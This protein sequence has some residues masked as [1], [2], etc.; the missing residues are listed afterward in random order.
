MRPVQDT[1]ASSFF[2]L[3]KISEYEI[4]LVCQPTLF[5]Y[6]MHSD[7]LSAFCPLWKKVICASSAMTDSSARMSRLLTALAIV[8][9]SRATALSSVVTGFSRYF[10]FSSKLCITINY[11]MPLTKNLKEKI[12]T[13]DAELSECL[14]YLRA[15]FLL[16]QQGACS[17]LLHGRPPICKRIPN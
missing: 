3:I 13:K 7:L 16:S 15:R 12:F 6:N 8:S 14:R 10:V 9:I 2:V 4:F 17:I 11:N 1:V 5:R